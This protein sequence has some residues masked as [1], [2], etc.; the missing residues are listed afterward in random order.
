M[1]EKYKTNKQL[2]FFS[3]KDIEQVLEMINDNN[4]KF[5]IKEPNIEIYNLEN[6]LLDL[7]KASSEVIKK[8]RFFPTYTSYKKMNDEAQLNNKKLDES[9][10][11]KKILIE[12]VK[13]TQRFFKGVIWLITSDTLPTE[14]NSW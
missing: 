1:N 2:V 9:K 12:K 6:Y 11:M 3:R 8:T 13:S 7:E 5:N 10:K 14:E 4:N